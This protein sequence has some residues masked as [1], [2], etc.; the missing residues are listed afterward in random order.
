MENEGTTMARKILNITLRIALF[1]LILFA[2]T[3]L[4]LVAGESKGLA[5]ADLSGGN[6]TA[7]TS[8][9]EGQTLYAGIDG[10][11]RPSGLYKS[12]DAG[13]TWQ[14]ISAGPEVAVKALAANPKNE[15]VLYAGSDG[16]AVDA[17]NN[18]WRSNNGGKTWQPLTLHLPASVAGITPAVTS[19]VIDPTHP[20]WI[21][22]GTAGNGLYRYDE[23]QVQFQLI[24]PVELYNAW[25]YSVTA[26]GQG[27]IYARTSKGLLRVKGNEWKIL[28]NV[29]EF[30]VS[31]A[32]A[33]SAANVLYVGTP[34][35]GAFKSQD[36]GLTW[37]K[38]SDGLPF[39]AGAPLRITSISVDPKDANRVSI[40]TAYQAGS[41][42]ANYLIF[43]SDNGGAK[44][45]QV[46][47]DI[48]PVVSLSTY[49]GNVFA[50]TT[51]GL[52]KYALSQQQENDFGLSIPAGLSNPSGIQMLI[53]ALT[54][55]LGALALLGRAEWLNKNLAAIRVRGGR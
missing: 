35:M 24:A 8:S 48:S 31:F 6:V 14:E 1:V 21:Y 41:E 26:D 50:G 3:S 22:V 42:F 38:I 32:V 53:L 44:W 17:Q 4:A 25:V 55:A 19:L 27:T 45:Q 52:A 9:N 12:I 51:T 11:P 13:L 30:P 37:Q 28:K 43:S 39:I 5:L 54:M 15:Q 16:G 7:L 23:K 49:N 47:K 20:E 40:S 18:L 33:G 10:G 34:S 2:G 36:A 46:A 29:P